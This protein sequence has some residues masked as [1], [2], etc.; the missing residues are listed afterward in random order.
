MEEVTLPQIL[1]ARENRVL[2][3]QQ[4]LERFGTPLICFTMNIAGPVKTSPLIARGFRLGL[5]RLEQQLLRLG[6]PVVHRQVQFLPTGCEALYA[7]DAPADVLKAMTV[8]LEEADRLGRLFDLDVLDPQGRKLDRPQERGCL[9]CGAAGR[10]CARSRAHSVEELQTKTCEILSEAL[11][12]HDRQ[13]IGELA[14]RALLFEA[15]TTPKPGLVDRMNNGSHTDMDLFSFLASS[16]ALQPYFVR[17]AT[18]GQGTKQLPPEETFRQL[19]RPGRLAEGNMFRATGGVNTHKG[20]IF[21]LGILCGALGRMDSGLQTPARRLLDECAA[22][23]KGL[24]GRELTANQTDTVG[25]QFFV[26]DG[27]LG[28]RGEVEQGLP[29]VASH[30]LP[31]LKQALAEGF[32]LEEAGCRALLAMMTEAE[33]TALL[34]RGGMDG[35]RFVRE[36]AARLASD[37]GKTQMLAFDREMIARNLSPG[38]SADLLAVCYLLHFLEEEQV[39]SSAT[40]Q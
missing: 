27:I 10:G 23:T 19:R 35:W 13:R 36:Q 2:Q 15:A 5:Q 17:C 16:A 18:I 24:T 3:Q 40:P 28:V 31:V 25:E 29:T 6:R 21:L 1:Q 22:M 8:D 20:A 32:S 33:D 14:C 4:L 12:C 26:S 38:G 39:A 34:H 30:G 11:A 9:I 7:V 37:Y